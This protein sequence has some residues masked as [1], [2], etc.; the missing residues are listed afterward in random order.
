M[1]KSLM[2]A[3][4]KLKHFL[5]V[6]KSFKKCVG[7]WWRWWGAQSGSCEIQGYF[8]KT[9]EIIKSKDKL[10]EGRKSMCSKL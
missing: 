8:Q 6:C 1:K 2:Q 10:S 4:D 5:F 3:K 9:K 7:R